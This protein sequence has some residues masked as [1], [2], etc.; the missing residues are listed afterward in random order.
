M[1]YF[2]PHIFWLEKNISICFI[3]SSTN[4]LFHPVLIEYLNSF[5]VYSSFVS[6]K[7]ELNVMMQIQSCISHVL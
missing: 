1:I 3:Y 6:N 4:A 5:I 7:Y 2:E